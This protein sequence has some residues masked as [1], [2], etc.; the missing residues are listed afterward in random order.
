MVLKDEFTIRK[1]F[2]S[3]NGCLSVNLQHYINIIFGTVTAIMVN[4]GQMASVSRKQNGSVF[5]MDLN[6]TF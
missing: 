3:G 6:V 1:L 5:L 2:G 4:R